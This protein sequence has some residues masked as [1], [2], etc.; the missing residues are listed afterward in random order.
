MKPYDEASNYLVNNLETV[1]AF[2]FP[3]GK[4]EGT[5][6]LVGNIQGQAGRS[7]SIALEPAARRGQYKDFSNSQPASR[8]LAKLWKIVRGI[9]EDNHVRFFSDLSA[10]SGQTFSWNG[11]NNA[12][13][14]AWPN[15]PD[16]LAK[17]SDADARRLAADPKR[18]YKLE[19]VQWL[20]AQGHLGL[21]QGDITFA[22][23]S[24]AGEVT[25]V[26]R[27]IGG[28]L[29]FRKSP[30]LWVLGDPGTLVSCIFTNR[31]GTWS[32]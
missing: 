21:Y 14:P 29:K 27:W 3:Q 20:H 24:L 4:R 10:F 13:G 32:P 1:C 5:N 8:N 26:H 11:S 6:F 18:Q 25:G 2:L 22:M 9:P 19:T 16:C 12:A 23:R 31:S 30:T 7:F 15:W 17:F 28:K